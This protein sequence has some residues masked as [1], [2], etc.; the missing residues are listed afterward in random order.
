MLLPIVLLFGLSTSS[1]ALTPTLLRVRG[2][3]NNRVP[4]QP[5][6]SANVPTPTL[7]DEIMQEKYGGRE[8]TVT[9]PINALSVFRQ[10][11]GFI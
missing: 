1:S 6:L 9:T 3:V 2:G 11:I 5:A 10:A 7:L 8:A 4:Q